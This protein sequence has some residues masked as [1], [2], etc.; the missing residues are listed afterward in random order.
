MKKRIAILSCV[1][2]LVAAFVSGLEPAVCPLCELRIDDSMYLVDLCAGVVGELPRLLSDDYHPEDSTFQFVSIAG[3]SGYRTTAPDYCE[4]NLPKDT[5]RMNHFRYCHAC[6]EMLRD[7]REN[8]Y[9]LLAFD[10]EQQTRT[11]YA[12]NAPSQYQIGNC[13]LTVYL[14]GNF[15]VLSMKP[16]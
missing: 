9:V 1:V 2:I 12:V 3:C 8:C 15:D 11:L 4:I 13:N 10:I 7:Y 16:I 6:R 14:D 5:R